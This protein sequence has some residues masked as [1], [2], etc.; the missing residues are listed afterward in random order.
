MLPPSI[1]T[2]Q[3][4]QY[5]RNI[6]IQIGIIEKHCLE[7]S[8]IATVP[9]MVKM[10]VSYDVMPRVLPLEEGSLGRRVA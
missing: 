7:L 3:G 10:R 8:M 5:T 1:E 6:T 4:R 9:C 2:S